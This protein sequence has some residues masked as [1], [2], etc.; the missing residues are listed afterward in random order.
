[1]Q[2]Q[3][4]RYKPSVYRIALGALFFNQGVVF[5]SWA[6]RIAD[7]KTKLNLNEADLGAILL[8]LPFGQMC[9][10]ALSGYLVTR[11]GSRKMISLAGFM[12]PTVLV[13]LAFANSSTALFATLMLFGVAA[14]LNNI[15]INTQAVGVEYVYGRPIMASFH[16][17]WSLAGFCGGLLSALLVAGNIGIVPNFIGVLC[18]ALTVLAVSWHF[19][20]PEDIKPQTDSAD[21]SKKR[22][23][24]S[25]T[26][27]IIIL[28]VIAFGCMSCE[29]TM[30]DWSV[31][32]FKDVIGA[33]RESTRIGYICFMCAMASGRFAGDFMIVKFGI[34]RVLQASGILVFLGMLVAVALPD[35][36]IS[37]LGFL[38]VGAGV[39]SVVP[40]CYSLA[41]KSR[42][43]SSGMAIATVS[44][45]GFFGFLM[46]P[47]LIGFIAH[48]SSL[49]WSLAL[50]ACI[51]LSVT[52]LA[53][54][55]KSR[56]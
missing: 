3:N 28:G 54:T 17:L 48:A 40:I 39:S 8:A 52:L 33:T 5:A 20:L 46:G 31:V 55:V 10:M 6:S 4:L 42:R 25:P 56:V 49:R 47:P 18:F 22:T 36:L 34:I 44:T 37:A 50:M 2:L 41:G 7:V 21:A 30:Y 27:F 51:G 12:Y 29:G 15:S 45:I 43:M 38:L 35:V 14:N 53:P 1:M 16:G 26:P 24:F 23:I 11:F 9:A 19:L 13:M 32:Y